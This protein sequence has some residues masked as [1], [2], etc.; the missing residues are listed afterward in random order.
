[1]DEPPRWLIHDLGCECRSG[2]TRSDPWAVHSVGQINCHQIRSTG[3]PCEGDFHIIVI[4]VDEMNDGLL[5][6]R[7]SVDGYAIQ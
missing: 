2:W 5:T 6:I 3:E 1:M 7:D 4:V